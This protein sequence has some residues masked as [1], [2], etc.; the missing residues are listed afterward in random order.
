MMNKLKYEVMPIVYLS[1][2]SKGVYVQAPKAV[3]CEAP[4]ARTRRLGVCG[5]G[6]ARQPALFVAYFSENRLSFNYPIT[7]EIQFFQLR[8][9][10]K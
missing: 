2:L 8:L 5:R 7:V 9:H 4:Q 3:T 6:G 10:R 1:N